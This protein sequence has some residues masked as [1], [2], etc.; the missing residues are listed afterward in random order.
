MK[1]DDAV[2]GGAMAL[3]G[4]KY[5]DEVRVLDIGS[6]RA[7]CGGTHVARTGDIGFFKITSQGGVAARVRRA[8]GAT[9]GGAL[10]RGAAMEGKPRFVDG[11]Y[12]VSSRGLQRK[13]QA[14]GQEQK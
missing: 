9:G 12:P 1:F 7:L 6:S 2:K 11:R 4:E 14:D 13:A 5:G 3:F 10:P 8:E